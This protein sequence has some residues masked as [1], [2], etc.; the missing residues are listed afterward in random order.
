MASVRLREDQ[1]LDEAKEI[2]LKVAENFVSEPPTKEE[3][4]RAKTR[5]TKQYELDIANSELVGTIISEF[6]AQGDW[7]L[8]FFAR[9]EVKKVTEQDVVRVAKAYL[10]PSNRT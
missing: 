4:E 3:V 6:A 7:R 9:D 10:K 1:S 2:L 8:L 5:L